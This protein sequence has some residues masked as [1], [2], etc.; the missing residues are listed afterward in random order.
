[1]RPAP[2]PSFARSAANPRHGVEVRLA[3]DVRCRCGRELK[4][5]DFDVVGLHVH[6]ICQGCHQDVVAIDMAD[7]GPFTIDQA[8]EQTNV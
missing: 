1:M 3:A 7:A 2:K 8:M 5:C 6:A 4:P